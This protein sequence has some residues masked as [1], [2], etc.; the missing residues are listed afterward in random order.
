MQQQTTTS[1]KNRTFRFD[2]INNSLKVFF[3]ILKLFS[4]TTLARNNYLLYNACSIDVKLHFVCEVPLA[5][6]TT[7]IPYPQLCK[8][9][10]MMQIFFMEEI[11]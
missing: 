7:G 10:A 9:D 5:M 6:A 1:R 2:L 11:S 8:V 3:N 4:T